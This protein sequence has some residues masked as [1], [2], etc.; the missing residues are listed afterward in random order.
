M[1][2]V[3]IFDLDKIDLKCFRILVF[4]LSQVQISLHIRE[5]H[6]YIWFCNRWKFCDSVSGQI[7]WVE[8]HFGR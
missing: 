7:V 8:I 2:M 6:V 5:T 4:A 1:H 3:T